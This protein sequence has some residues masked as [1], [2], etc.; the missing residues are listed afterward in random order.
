MRRVA[1][2]NGIIAVR[3]SDYGAMTWY[4][5]PPGMDDWLDLYHRVAR[6]NGGEPDA[7]RRLKAWALEAGFTDITAT[8]ATW[9]LRHTRGAPV[10]GGL[11][12]D[13]TVASA[14]AER[15][16]EGGH[17]TTDRLRAVSA[18]WREWG[19]RPEAGSASCTGRFCAERKPDGRLIGEIRETSTTEVHIMVPLLIVL[20]LA[21]ILFGAGFAVKILWWIALAVLVLWLLGFLARGTRPAAAGARWYRW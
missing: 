16:T 18:A 10:V 17:A 21:I 11:W 2:P 8:S 12:A 6:A 13:R 14:Y 19:E 9:T 5:P 3:D 20:L 1:R 7:G 4:P 15:A